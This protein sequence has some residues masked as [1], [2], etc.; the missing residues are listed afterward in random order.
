MGDLLADG[1]QFKGGLEGRLAEIGGEGFEHLGFV[2]GEQAG[3][4]IELLKSPGHR[5]AYPPVDRLAH[6]F[7]RKH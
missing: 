3:E 1:H 6:R 7:D 2:V 5:P 4:P